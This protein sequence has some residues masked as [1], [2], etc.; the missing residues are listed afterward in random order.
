MEQCELIFC[1][2]LRTT[3]HKQKEKTD[4]NI[5]HSCPLLSCFFTTSPILIWR[6]FLQNSEDS[7]IS[8]I[9]SEGRTVVGIV[10]SKFAVL[11]KRVLMWGG[12]ELRVFTVHHGTERFIFDMQL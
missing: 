2:L 10:L 6:I 12:G 5:R 4:G 8:R 7:L 1:T 3:N 9:W 11:F